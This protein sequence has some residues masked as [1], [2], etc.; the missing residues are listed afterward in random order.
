MHLVF[1]VK[2]SKIK[3]QEEMLNIHLFATEHAKYNNTARTISS[4]GSASLKVEPMA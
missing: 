2:R 4:I 1:K 3:K